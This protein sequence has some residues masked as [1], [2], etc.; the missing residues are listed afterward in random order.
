MK[1]VR[2]L[3]LFSAMAI[4]GSLVLSGCYTQFEVSSDDNPEEVAAETTATYQPP[5]AAD[6]SYNPVY[7]V[8]APVS[9]FPVGGSSAPAPSSNSQPPVAKREVGNQR[10]APS[11]PA[12]AP[13]P[14]S[15]GTTRHGR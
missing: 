9:F 8:G 6:I 5:P 10:S 7:V 12:P 2:L 13:A 1:P 15:T 4:G 11:S 14:R 3:A